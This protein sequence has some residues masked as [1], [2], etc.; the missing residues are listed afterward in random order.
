MCP[1]LW[2]FTRS[3]LTFVNGDVSKVT[4]MDFMFEDAEGF[5]LE[6]APWY[7]E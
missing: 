1:S 4:T 2:H 6:N 5:N 7:H 3:F